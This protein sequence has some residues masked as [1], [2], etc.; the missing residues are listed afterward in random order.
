VVEEQLVLV[1]Q[2]VVMVVFQLFQ[3][4]HPQVVVEVVLL[5]VQMEDLEEELIE[6]DPE[7]VVIHLP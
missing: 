5:T 6:L 2:L 4:F 1:M 3:Q 7:V